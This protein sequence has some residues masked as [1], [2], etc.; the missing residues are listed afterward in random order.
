MSHPI[1]TA[2]EQGDT[3]RIVSRLTDDAWLTMPPE[4][5]EYQGGEAIARFGERSLMSASGHRE[6]TPSR[7]IRLGAERV[8]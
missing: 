6:R 4:P 3:K 1:A 8:A 2:V 5:Y 7:R